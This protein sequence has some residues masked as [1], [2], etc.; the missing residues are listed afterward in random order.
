M[1][2]NPPPRNLDVEAS[3][4]RLLLARFSLPNY[5]GALFVMTRIEILLN[6]TLVPSIFAAP[7]FQ[8]F[9]PSETVFDCPVRGGWGSAEDV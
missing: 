3:V 2:A 4:H 8:V 7:K 1:R 6:G 5:F 9:W